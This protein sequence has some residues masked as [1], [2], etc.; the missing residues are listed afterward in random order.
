MSI[1]EMHGIQVM[2]HVL[3]PVSLSCGELSQPVRSIPA[4]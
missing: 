1:N 3:R 4:I 2:N